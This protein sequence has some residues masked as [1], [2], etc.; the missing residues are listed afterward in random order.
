MISLPLVTQ[1][2]TVGMI[3]VFDT[4]ERD[5]AEVREF[6]TT[7]ARTIAD[8]HAER[9]PARQPAAQQRGALSELVLLGD[10]PE[11]GRG[12]RRHW[13]A[14]PRERLRAILAA[15]DCDIW[16]IDG[17]RM[18]CLASLD[19]RGWDAE[20]MGSERD[21]RAYEATQA[22]LAA[23]APQVF[24][25]LESAGLPDE[26]MAAYRRWGFRSMVSLPLVAEGR[27]I[28]LIDVFDTRVRDYTSTLDFIRGAGR[29]LAGAFEKA[30]LVERLESGN[31]DLRVLTEAGMEFGATLDVD[32]VLG[33][34]AQRIL[35]VSS[36]DLCDIYGLSRM[37]PTPRCCCHSAAR[38]CAT[39]WAAAT[40]SAT[41]APSPRRPRPAS[42][43][44]GWTSSP[45]RDRT[46]AT[47][48][49]P[50]SGATHRS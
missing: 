49:T 22:A 36:S 12:P 21:L 24:G 9:R 13:R 29:L 5:F 2:E 30:M 40:R 42:P 43:S 3:D 41:S 35:E 19:S 32:A 26:E 1:G 48:K 46:S 17:D 8:S 14:S 10:Q 50:E 25:D 27:P 11:R 39:W 28:G 23:N 16:M 15:E 18:R 45:T 34:V 20:E 44:C 7:A 47:A 37:S 4:R 38:S 31:R 6:V 33:T